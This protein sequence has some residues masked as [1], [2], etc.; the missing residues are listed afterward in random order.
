MLTGDAKTFQLNNIFG[1][2]KELRIPF[3]PFSYEIYKE[4]DD[5]KPIEIE[6]D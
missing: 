3:K 1:I 4:T 5:N 6:L 2:F